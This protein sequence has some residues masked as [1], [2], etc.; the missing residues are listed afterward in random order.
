MVLRLRL[1][2]VGACL[3][4]TGC[5]LTVLATF[6]VTW[7]R[8]S[9]ALRGPAVISLTLRQLADQF[10]PPP[11]G[12][13]FPGADPRL[14]DASPTVM[15]V[16]AALLAIGAAVMLA[17]RRGRGWLVATSVTLVASACVLYT[18]FAVGVPSW[19]SHEPEFFSWWV[20]LAA[21]ILGFGASAASVALS[22][23]ARE[24]DRSAEPAPVKA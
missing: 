17:T 1:L 21:A 10:Q 18:T 11:G 8:V 5:V 4:L 12:G 7:F 20:A 6:V 24:M 9:E 19:F 22:S 14:W 23:N 2:R 13:F 15:T 16:A 3:A